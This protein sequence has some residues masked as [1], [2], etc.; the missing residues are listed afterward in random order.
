MVDVLKTDNDKETIESG[1]S[2]LDGVTWRMDIKPKYLIS[3]LGVGNQ[4]RHFNL[5]KDVRLNIHRLFP[6]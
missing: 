4:E 2:I 1:L 3:L 5:S 6:C